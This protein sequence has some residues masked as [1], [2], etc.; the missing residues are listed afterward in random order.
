M[1]RLCHNRGGTDATTAIDGA[2]RKLVE[3]ASAETSVVLVAELAEQLAEYMLVDYEREDWQDSPLIES[4]A[5]VAALLEARG[6]EI[7]GAILRVLRNASEAGHPI[8][9]A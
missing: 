4:L 1:T 7:P 2:A 5:R 3:E 8:G 9:V 6:C